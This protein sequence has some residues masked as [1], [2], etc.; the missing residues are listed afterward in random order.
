MAIRPRLEAR[1]APLVAEPGGYRPVALE[2][3]AALALRQGDRAKAKSLY[4]EI[5]DNPEAPADLRARAAQ[6]LVTLED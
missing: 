4:S 6:V 3:N 5:A 2:L 1:L